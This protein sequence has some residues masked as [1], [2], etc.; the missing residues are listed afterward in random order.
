MDGH[1]LE[2]LVEVVVG[3]VEAAKAGLVAEGRGQPALAGTGR[4]GDEDRETLSDVVAGG[5]CHHL[6]LFESPFR[7]EA[8]LL[9]GGLVAKAGLLQQPGVAVRGA[10]FTLGLEH[11]FQAVVKGQ[12]VHSPRLDEAVPARCHP[13]QAQAL[14]LH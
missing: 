7:V 9:D 14:K 13:R 5:E 12:A 3:G 8:D 2:E 10:L 4:A 6:G 11:Q 1:L